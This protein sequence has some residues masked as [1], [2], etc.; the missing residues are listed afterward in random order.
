M[1]NACWKHRSAS[2]GWSHAWWIAAS[3]LGIDQVG[4]HD[5]FEDLGGDSLIAVQLLARIRAELNVE[6]PSHS[7]L[8]APTIAELAETM[9]MLSKAH[10]GDHQHLVAL[11]EGHTRP[12]LFLVH[13]V[14]GEVYL[15]R[16]LVSSIDPVQPVYGLRAQGTGDLPATVEAMAEKY[17]AEIRA[18]QP[19]GP[20]VLAGASFGGLVAYELATRLEAAGERVIHVVMFDTSVRLLASVHDDDEIL[21][22]LMCMGGDSRITA[23][24]LRALPL[25]EKLELFCR[26]STIGPRMLPTTDWQAIEPFLRIWRTC[27]AAIVR[28]RPRPSTVPILFFRAKEKDPF[29]PPDPDKEW[30]DLTAGRITV[31]DVPGNHITMCALPNVRTMAEPLQDLLTKLRLRSGVRVRG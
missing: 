21:A 2:A 9:A 19:H 18:V 20:Y 15:Y 12:A 7:L 5:S 10:T 6:L 1:A 8:V 25:H 4:V 28:Y 16:D 29:N 13:P 17:L 22:Y 26:H 14:G 3:F 24:E 27:T 11:R 30:H 23:D 31:Q